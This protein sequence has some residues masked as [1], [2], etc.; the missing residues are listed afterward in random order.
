MFYHCRIYN[1]HLLFVK[2]LSYIAS[3]FAALLFSIPANRDHLFTVLILPQTFP[4]F[5]FC[6]KQAFLRLK[7]FFSS[8]FCEKQAFS[9]SPLPIG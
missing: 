3:I 5:H 9:L 6:N 8:P 7:R 1:F 2:V 4:L